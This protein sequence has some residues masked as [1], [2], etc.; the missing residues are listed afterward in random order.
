MS[1][2]DDTPREDVDDD[3]LPHMTGILAGVTLFARVLV[4]G[5]AAYGAAG[6][7]GMIVEFVRRGT[8]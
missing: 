8:L 2:T 1:D 4:A 6:L 3:G 5:L 7:I